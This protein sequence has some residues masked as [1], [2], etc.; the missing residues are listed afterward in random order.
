MVFYTKVLLGFFLLTTV[1]S[2]S[3]R[4][5]YLKKR[6]LKIDDPDYLEN[7]KHY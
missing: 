3:K 1:S 7:C 2:L 5:D 6:Q 4:E